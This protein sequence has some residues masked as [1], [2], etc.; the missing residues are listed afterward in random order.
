MLSW[1][2]QNIERALK[3][4]DHLLFL[5]KD[6]VKTHVMRVGFRPVQYDIDGQTLVVKT[7]DDHYVMS[8]TEDWRLESRPVEWG[9][10]PIIERM[11][12]IDS[13]NPDSI[14]NRMEELNAKADESK[15]RD[16][17]RRTE[18]SIREW[19]PIFKEAVKDINTSTMKKIE[20][21]LKLKGF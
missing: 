1:R 9:E 3:R 13:H 17:L 11:R 5:K 21:K 12:E 4:F 6:A 19:Q 2:E 18:D 15:Q 10:L 8:L 7:R 14:V 20:A 16:F